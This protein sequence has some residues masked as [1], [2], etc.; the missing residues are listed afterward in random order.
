MTQKDLTPLAEGSLTPQGRLIALKEHQQ[1]IE[2]EINLFNSQ[3][4]AV[5]TKIAHNLQEVANLRDGYNISQREITEKIDFLYKSANQSLHS[6]QGIPPIENETPPPSIAV[7]SQDPTLQHQRAE[8]AQPAAPTAQQPDHSPLSH[9]AH[10]SHQEP[11]QFQR[12]VPAQDDHVSDLLSNF[13]LAESEPQ[14]NHSHLHQES[15]QNQSIDQMVAGMRQPAPEDE[16]L[17][18]IGIAQSDPNYQGGAAEA[19]SF[20]N[21]GNQ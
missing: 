9:F 21:D 3:R 6:L 20:R 19:N 13:G 5:I 4:E 2:R 11:S 12:P 10:T 1:A 14:T 17:A 16:G 8:Q 7:S 18:D 15:E